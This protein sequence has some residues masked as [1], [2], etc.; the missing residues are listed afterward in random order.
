MA[1]QDVS[2]NEQFRKRIAGYM[3]VILIFIDWSSGRCNYDDSK[4][5]LHSSIL[6]RVSVGRCFSVVN[7][8]TD[9][10][11]YKTL[12]IFASAAVVYVFISEERKEHFI[13]NVNLYLVGTTAGE[14]PMAIAFAVNLHY[15]STSY[16]DNTLAVVYAG[17]YAPISS[18]IVGTSIWMQRVKAVKWLMLTSSVRNTASATADRFPP[19]Y[20]F[21]TSS[22][23]V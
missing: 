17:I 3:K 8:A 4:L 20:G 15:I 14:I 23:S 18:C 11:T 5:S 10:I 2:L 19:G 16:L 21:S 13:S 12:T 7:E 1:D 22:P 9:Q 6:S